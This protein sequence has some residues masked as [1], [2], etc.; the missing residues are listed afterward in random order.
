MATVRDEQAESADTTRTRLGAGRSGEVWLV[1]G[2]EGSA[3]VK[4]FAGDTLSN[5]IHYLFTGAPNPYIW[6]EDAIR[7]SLH[8]RKVLGAL[9]SVW[10]GPAL[11]VADA[12]E[13]AWN[14]E[15][16][17]W[18]V[19]T[20]Y[21]EG[22]PIPLLHTRRDRNPELDALRERIMEPLQRHA[23]EA[24][25]DGIVWQAGMGNPVGLNNF[26]MLEPGGDGEPRFAFID[27]ES[28][29][30]ALF[31]MNPLELFRFYLPRSFAHGHPLFDDVDT[32]RLREYLRANADVLRRRL[33]SEGWEELH[34]H[35]ERLALHQER[36]HAQ[37]RVERGIEYHLR[38]RRL[39]PE[40]AEHFLRHRW[41]WRA[42]EA[43]RAAFKGLSVL[44][45]RLPVRIGEW[46]MGIDYPGLFR[47]VGRFVSSQ[48]YRTN[49]A[50][51]YVRGRVRE[52]RERGQLDDDH[53]RALMEEIRHDRASTYL[54]DFGAHL[55]MKATFQ[56]FEF[57]LFAALVAAGI[58][59]VWFLAVL[60]ALDGLIYRT[61]YTLYRM[62][63]EA[64]ARRPLPWVALLV[65]L[66][67]L[68][69]SLAF[70]AQM[71]YSAQDRREEVARFTI[72]D[73]FTR[74]GVRLPIWGGKDTLTEH[75]LNRFA[76]RVMLWGASR[77]R[78]GT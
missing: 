49:L 69:G 35:T 72:Y 59:P 11:R 71:V 4:V 67:P 29:V 28:G 15:N 30:P 54:T 37:D 7:A 62:A 18:E 43:A 75:T 44:V 38:K 76:H 5:L 78:A 31:P 51:R 23:I 46:L 39:T 8:R 68:L 26:L 65:G 21:V 64:A 70:P 36:W 45:V 57:T 20:E 60:I 53:A 17:A 9:C 47:N 2:P 41:R 32:D 77:R 27:A 24:G 6:N 33:G 74:L 55:G 25:L 56:V 14:E 19:A 52:W 63:R 22:E 66:V 48:K 10:F 3:A 1:E 61:A 13:V 50:R 42:R 34:M 12:Y 40:L 16:L 58:V 73:L